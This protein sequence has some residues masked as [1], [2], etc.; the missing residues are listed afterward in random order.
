VRSGELTPRLF[1]LE[2]KDRLYMGPK[3]AG[4]FTLDRVPEGLDAVLVSTGTGIAPYMSMLRTALVCGGPR[5]FAVL[6]GAR[7]SWDLG[8]RAEL[9]ALSRRCANLVYLPSITRPHE[10]ATWTGLSGYLQDL[11]LAPEV[12]ECL[13]FPTRPDRARR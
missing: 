8:Y 9:T 10:D 2:V 12:T 11:I 13:G 6:H 7:F 4:I 1:A 3:A 5:R